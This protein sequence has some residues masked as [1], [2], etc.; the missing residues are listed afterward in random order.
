VIQKL[1]ATCVAAGAIA[2][3][4]AAGV[5]AVVS[6]T[7][8]EAPAVQ[9]VVFGTPMPLNPVADMPSADQ[10][11]SVLYGLADPNVPFASK[12]YLVEG[13]LGRLEARTADAL[14]RK[15]VANGQVP[16]SFSI[17]DI[18]PAGPGIATANV[19]AT[20]PGMP[21]TTQA[22]TFVDQGGWKLSRNSATAVLAIFNG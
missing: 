10:L 1:L 3:G 4:A 5:T 2:G 16:L 9:P 19:T 6:I 14:M 17:A 7:P 21:A 11:N 22:I 8:T 20:G 15:A 13:G 12:S 18:V